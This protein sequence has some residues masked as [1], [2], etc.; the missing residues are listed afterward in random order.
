LVLSYLDANQNA[1]ALR[2]SEEMT[3]SATQILGSNSVRLAPFLNT[4]ANVLLKNGESAK[5]LQIY[6]QIL[7]LEGLAENLTFSVALNRVM[8]GT[9]SLEIDSRSIEL[10]RWLWAQRA[11]LS[12]DESR[13]RS[14]LVLIRVLNASD[15]IPTAREVSHTTI[16]TEGV[17]DPVRTELRV[18]QELLNARPNSTAKVRLNAEL[19]AANSIDPNVHRALEEL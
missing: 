15:D 11:K 18:W 9:S 14:K 8:V 13:A 1:S 3:N 2:V 17:D 19:R 7:G 5:A 16:A 12:T 6:D 10:S 4:R